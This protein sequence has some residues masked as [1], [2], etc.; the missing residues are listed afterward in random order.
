MLLPYFEVDLAH[1]SGA[2]T[3]FSISNVG[4]AMQLVNVT[5][6]TDLGVPTVAFPIYLTGFD[7]ETFNLRDVF[8]GRIPASASVGQDPADTISP[9]GPW[10]QDLE[11]PGLH[12]SS[13]G[14]DSF[15]LRWSI[16]YAGPTAVRPHPCS[17]AAPAAWAGPRSPAAT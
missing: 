3:L 16:L 2:T 7:I 9:Q 14:S 5:L 17:A 15:R 1:P 4:P 11:P 6:W 8:A 13:A 12:R 10:S